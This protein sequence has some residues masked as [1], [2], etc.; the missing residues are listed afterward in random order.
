MSKFVWLGAL[1]MLAGAILVFVFLG[2]TLRSA[3]FIAF[4]LVCPGII[5]Y[6]IIKALRRPIELPL[7]PPPETRGMLLEWIAPVYDFYCPKI[8]LGPGFRKLT[9]QYAGVRS[10]EHIL[11]V[12]CGTGVLTRLASE[13]VGPEGRVI[14]ID[15]GPKMIAS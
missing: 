7:E 1:S 6:G 15:P 4:L 11:D 13:T 12:G 10:G 14:G 9:L 5:I 8:G 2:F 3:L